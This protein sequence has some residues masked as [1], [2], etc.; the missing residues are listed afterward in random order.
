MQH[1]PYPIYFGVTLDKTLTY[2]THLTN[3]TTK[4]GSRNNIIQTLTGIDWSADFNYFKASAVSLVY[5]AAKCCSPVWLNSA[6][7]KKY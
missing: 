5:S 6:Y 7:T 4:I 3:I 2:K 1:N